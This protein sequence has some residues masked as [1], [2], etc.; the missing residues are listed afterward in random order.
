M[1][2]IVTWSC[3]EFGGL[4]DFGC[5]CNF[6]GHCDFRGDCDKELL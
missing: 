3:Y 1:G 4:C 6:G 2:V 5:P